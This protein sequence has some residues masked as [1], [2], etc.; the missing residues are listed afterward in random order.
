M[1]LGER[2]KL[3]I[4]AFRQALSTLR[5]AA[6]M[7]ETTIVRDALIQRYEYAFE[8]AWRAVARALTDLGV[9]V[10]FTPGQVLRDA[11]TAKLIDDADAWGELQK[12]RNKTSHAYKEKIAIEVAAL[13]RAKALGEFEKLLAR[14]EAL[15]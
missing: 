3:E 6:G 10:T 9:N 8:A 14:L 7:T 5:E 4:A 12:A 2:A 11:L 13:V 15:G 1:T